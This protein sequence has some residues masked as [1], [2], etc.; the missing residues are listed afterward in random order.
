MRRTIPSCSCLLLVAAAAVSA[1][2]EKQQQP[3]CRGLKLTEFI[4]YLQTEASVEFD[5]SPSVAER[6]NMSMEQLIGR[7]QGLWEGATRFEYDRALRAEAGGYSSTVG[8]GGGGAGGD[9]N[10]DDNDDGDEDDG[11]EVFPY[12]L[13]SKDGVGD[14]DKVEQWGGTSTVHQ[15][16]TLGR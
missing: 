3:K 7:A 6:E 12:I 16:Q 15:Q 8:G 11:P 2:T 1:A 13:C 4:A 9:N 14:A 10:N 5:L